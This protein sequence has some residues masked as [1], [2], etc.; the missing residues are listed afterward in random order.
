MKKLIGQDTALGITTNTWVHTGDQGQKQV[1]VETIQDAEPVFKKAKR[2]AQTQDSKSS[3][4]FAASVANNVL[5]DVTYA[6][7]RTWGV[8]VKDAF[9]E[10]MKGKTDRSQEILKMLKQG[11]D[12]RKFQAKHYA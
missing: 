3:F 9:A 12:Y 10:I 4:R 8:S 7:A 6:A 2:L 1:T 11:R 5:N